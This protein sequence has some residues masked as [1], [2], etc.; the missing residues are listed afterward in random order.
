VLSRAGLDIR[1]RRL[2][3]PDD[4]LWLKA[5]V[6]ADKVPQLQRLEHAITT[7]LRLAEA[8]SGPTLERCTFAGAPDWLRRNRRATPDAGL[9]VFNSIATVYLSHVEYGTLR[10]GMRE[11]LAPWG[12]RGLWVEFERSRGNPAGPLNLSAHRLVNGELHTRV[13][14]TGE[15]RPQEM[16]IVGDWDFLYMR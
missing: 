13:L 15:A 8:A 10:R 4:R 5:C 11:A 14:A 12:T 1:P 3:D 7:Y 2:A 6:W 16:R 9:L